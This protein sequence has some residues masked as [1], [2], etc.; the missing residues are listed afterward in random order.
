MVINN[1][2]I[3]FLGTTGV[4]HVLV[5]AHLYLGEEISEDLSN[6]KDF[7]D[8][9]KEL[10]GYPI[11]VGE[12]GDNNQVYVLGAGL[13]VQMVKR[14]IEQ[15]TEIMGVPRDNLLVQPIYIK[16]D[17]LFLLY[18]LLAPGRRK[19]LIRVYERLIKR[20]IKRELPCLD[21]QIND[22]KR[23]LLKES[24]CLF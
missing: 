11:F 24:P 23:L 4:H 10:T 18:S 15:L 2:N 1:M 22:F 9:E 3:I 7:N 13:E 14:S 19:G 6:I 8:L 16:L 5:A 20:L 21:K 17:K 12:D